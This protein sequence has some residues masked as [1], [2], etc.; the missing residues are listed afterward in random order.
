MVQDNAAIF[1]HTTIKRRVW[2]N[3][4]MV[5]VS[6][7]ILLSSILPLTAGNLIRDDQFDVGVRGFRY[8]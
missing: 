8:F 7:W 6:R 5:V 4:I 1:V 2:L 3:T